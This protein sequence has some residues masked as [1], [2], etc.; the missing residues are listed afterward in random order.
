MLKSFCA[1]MLL[2]AAAA[3]GAGTTPALTQDA[4]A[5]PQLINYQGKLTDAAGNPLNTTVDMTFNIYDGTTG[6]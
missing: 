1:G 5:I 2:A 4:V 6:I 3:S